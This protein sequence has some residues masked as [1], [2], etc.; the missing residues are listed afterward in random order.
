MKIFYLGPNGTNSDVAA[1]SIF[2]DN[3]SVFI[4]LNSIEEIFEKVA[5]SHS[6][7]GVIPFENSYQGVINSSLNGLIDYDLKITKEFNFKI[8]HSFCSIN[9]N[10]KSVNKIASHPQVFGQCNKWIRK[11]YPK[12]EKII[13]TSTADA[14]QLAKVDQSI[15]CIVNNYASN[16]FDLNLHQSDIQ[17]SPNNTTRFLVIGKMIE[18]K[19]LINKTS[20]MINLDDRPGSLLEI[21]QPF[22]KLGINMTRI[23][24][25]PSRN[26]QYQHTFFIDFE[27]FYE[28]KNITKLLDMLES[29][30]EE[31]RVIGSY[32]VIS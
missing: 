13:C 29:M 11:N 25:R 27:G 8:I 19:G 6:Y 4:G 16:L 26:N 10:T 7:T 2:K 30:T 9:A 18:D 12:A 15:Y 23:E 1:R 17:D 32:E 21:L 3:K 20:V 24:T 22:N 31:I 14:A 28:D 5:L